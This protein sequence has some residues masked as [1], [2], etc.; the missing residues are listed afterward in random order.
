[1]KIENLILPVESIRENNKN[2]RVITDLQLERLVQSIQQLPD[3]LNLRPLVINA[4]NVV[5]G[6]NMRLRAI[7]VLKMTEVPVIKVEGLTPEKE[8]EFLIKNNLNY[9]DW[10]WFELENSYDFTALP[11][12]GLEVPA[13]IFDDDEEPDFEFKPVNNTIRTITFTYQKD[14][15]VGILDKLMAI[16]RREEV[17]SFTEIILLLLN[18]YYEEIIST[19]SRN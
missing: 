15:F 16:Q 6:G 14:E 7:R 2:P 8:L 5:L 12:W 9:G 18:E 10:N 13:A 3:M 11:N 1:M 19:K 4:D 17:E